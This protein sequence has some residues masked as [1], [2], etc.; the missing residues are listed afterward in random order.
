VTGESPGGLNADGAPPAPGAVTLLDLHRPALRQVALADA[1]G[2][3]GRLGEVASPAGP[4]IGPAPERSWRLTRTTASAMIT[5]IGVYAG[6]L[7][8]A[9]AEATAPSM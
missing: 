9:S 7:A 8:V 1:A 6:V 2:P 4:G 5:Q 3:H